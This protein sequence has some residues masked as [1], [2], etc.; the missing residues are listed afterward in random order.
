MPPVGAALATIGSWVATAAP[1]LT[2][3]AA[4]AGTAATVSQ[5]NQAA[6][7]AKNAA[8]DQAA[9]QVGLESELKQRQATSESEANAINVRDAARRRQANLAMGAG[10]RQDTILTGPLGVAGEAPGGKK[11]LLGT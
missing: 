8:A 6:K 2:A 11:T 1:V 4:V 3:G 7:Q 5:G 9:R 10:G